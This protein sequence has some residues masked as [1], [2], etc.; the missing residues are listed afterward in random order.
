MEQKKDS[1]DKNKNIKF[2]LSKKMTFLIL[3]F[4]ALM[5]ALFGVLSYKTTKNIVMKNYGEKANHSSN[6]VAHI[7]DTNK[8]KY[9]KK[10]LE[11]DED[12]EKIVKNLDYIRNKLDLTYLYVITQT[13]DGKD[14]YI[15]D[16]SYIDD[17]VYDSIE[18]R[19]LLGNATE[20]ILKSDVA[21]KIIK[22]KEAI[23]EMEIS[24]DDLWGHLA[25]SYSPILD[26]NG[27]VLALVGSDISMGTIFKEINKSVFLTVILVGFIVIICLFLILYILKRTIIKP[28]STMEKT[29][30]EF[31]NNK[32]PVGKVISIDNRD[33][34]GKLA[35]ALNCM[36]RDI[37]NY[38]KN[39][40]KITSEKEQVAAE[41]SVA[42]QIQTSML[43]C[44]FP[45]FPEHKEFDIFATMNPAKTVGGDFYDFF[46]IGDNRLGFVISDVSG[47]GIS[48]A[49]FMVIAKILINNEA[50]NGENPS[51]ILSKVNKQ[52]C[53]NN[54]IGMFATAFLGII[55]LETGEFVFS[56]AGHTMPLIKRKDS[57]F[58]YFKVKKHFV[59]GGMPNAK[60]TSE[61][62]YL[63]REDILFLYTDGITEATNEEKEL[64]ASKRLKQFLDKL[65]VR[66]MRLQD[67]VRAVENEIKEFSQNEPQADDITVLIFKYKK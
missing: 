49:L 8:I 43:P 45:A 14:V 55:S 24:Y 20:Q 42:N 26:E 65:D 64:F 23:S 36:M 63:E 5:I 4:S 2:G 25:T 58:E 13:E 35:I 53:M 15:Y 34:I 50:H 41:L 44:I 7:L 12:Y 9:Y 19:Q 40:K 16:T 22:T 31:V 18:E 59:L 54:D 32:N 39:I 57:D 6:L 46:L 62:F 1:N 11:T 21:K 60:Y 29:V 10:T 52:L 48:A 33:E 61:K 30:N 67:I 66:H 51:D 37:E 28:I 17:G 3:L 47:K 38:I 27:N 56:N